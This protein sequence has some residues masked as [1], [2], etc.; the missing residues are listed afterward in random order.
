MAEAA[1]VFAALA[2]AEPDWPYGLYYHALATRDRG[3]MNRAV[4]QL[5]RADR[6]G[7][8]PLEGRL[9]LVLS[10]L[11]TGQEDRGRAQLTE[12]AM[13]YAGQSLPLGPLYAPARMPADLRRQ[14]LAIPA[15][16]NLFAAP[17]F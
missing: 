1:P 7:M 8:L 15:C 5:E 13:R 3:V 16:G 2:E 10:L 4:R 12:F 6:A 11:T 14:L 17:E 9:Y